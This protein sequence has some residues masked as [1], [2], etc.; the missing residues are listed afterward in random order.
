MIGRQTVTWRDVRIVIRTSVERRLG[1][2]LLLTYLVRALFG[3]AVVVVS[4]V[5]VHL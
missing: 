4:L 1:R 2:P 5:V 3:L